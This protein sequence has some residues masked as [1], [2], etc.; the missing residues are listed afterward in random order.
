MH[1]EETRKL[2]RKRLEKHK[3]AVRQIEKEFK[4]EDF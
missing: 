2:A 3:D 4:A 1:F